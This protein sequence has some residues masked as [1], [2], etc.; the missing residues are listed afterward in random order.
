MK[1]QGNQSDSKL[2]EIF[3]HLDKDGDKF[4]TREELKAGIKKYLG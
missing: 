4:L 3:K 1:L 2:Q